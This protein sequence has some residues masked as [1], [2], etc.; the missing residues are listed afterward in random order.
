[1]MP[2]AAPVPA[3]AY[4]LNLPPATDNGL[5]LTLQEP[6]SVLD[7]ASNL[8]NSAAGLIS[9][10]SSKN[11]EEK[12]IGTVDVGR[13]LVDVN[14]AEHSGNPIAK[15]DRDTVIEESIGKPNT[16][17]LEPPHSLLVEDSEQNVR[18]STYTPENNIG[19]PPNK[20]E[21]DSPNPAVVG[22]IKH[23]AGI[24]NYSFDVPFASLPGRGIDAS[25]GMTYNSR[26]WN[27]TGEGSY[28]FY[29]Y[30]VDKNWIA[31]GF[32]FGYGKLTS[33]FQSKTVVLTNNQ[34][35]TFNEVVPEGFTDPD[36]TR[37]QIEC[38]ASSV[39][40]N[41]Q[42]FGGPST[43]C[44]EYGTMDGTFVKVIYNGTRI[45]SPYLVDDMSAYAT[46]YF[47]LI[48]AGGSKVTYTIPGTQFAA[49]DFSR[50]HYPTLIQD[51]NGNQ[52]NIAYK[53]GKDNIEY[54]R[55]TLGRQIK[56]YYDTAAEK[57]L[58]AVTVPGFN[59]GAERQT[60]RFYYEENVALNYQGKFT[61]YATAPATYRALKY[62]YFPST[63]AGYRYDYHPNF[64]MITKISKLTGMAVTG[65]S[66]TSTG[67]VTADG[68]TAST[69]E[70]TYP[71]DG[72]QTPLTDVPKYT[73]RTD[74]WQGRTTA[75]API[76]Y[77]D[78][79]EPAAGADRISAVI[80]KDTSFDIEYKTVSNN[81]L[82]WKNGLTKETIVT[83]L[84]GPSRQYRTTMAKT[85]YTWEEGIADASGR[86]IPIVR[87]VEVTNDAGQIKAVS[88][89]YDGYNNQTVVREHDLAAPGVLGNELRRTETT[90]ETGAGWITN[91]M[92]RLPKEIKTIVNNT[93]VSKVQ[94][95]YDNYVGNPLAP[96]PGVIQHDPAYNGDS[97][98]YQCNPHYVCDPGDYPPNCPLEYDQCPYSDP[99]TNFRGNVTKV[100]A[101]SNASLTTDPDASAHTM[102]YDSAGNVVEASM[103]CCN[104]KT[105]E[106]AAA[107]QYAYA[108]KETKGSSPQLVNEGTYDF[109]TGLPLSTKDENN[110]TTN[111][112]YDAATLRR[113]RVDA[114]NGAWSTVEYND[115]Q[116]PYSVKS[117]S[118]LDATRSISSWSFINGA[119]QG[120]RSRSL[121]ASGYISNDV[122]FDIMGRPT[123]SYNP[124]TVTGLSDARPAG[125]KYSEAIVIDPLGRTLSTKLPDDTIVQ[126]EYSG[127]TATMTDQAGKKR[128]QLA[129]ALG[130]IVRV[131]EPDAA[132][133]LGAVTTPIQP[134]FYEYDGN[135]NLI[136]VTQTGNGVTQE[137]L[138]KYDALSR[139][140]AE[141]QVEAAATLNDAG[142]KIGAGGLWTGVYKYNAD[143]LLLEGV[144]ARGVKSA[145][146]Y[147]GLNR[148]TS[149]TYTGE[150]G[151]QT[152]QVTYT[153][154]EAESGFF[155]VGRLTKVKTAAN[156]TY[157]TP[158]TIQNYDYDSVGQVVKHNQS[159]G[160]QS[161]NLEYGYNLAGQLI[162]E[163]YPSGKVVNMTVDN[164]GV[165]QTIADSQR[166]YLNGISINNQGLLSQLNLGNGNAETFSYNDRFQMTSQSLNKGSEV[167][168]KYDYS[169]GQTDLTTGN[170]DTTKNNEQLGKIESFIG[171]NKQASQRFAYDEL[172]RLSESRE[173]RGDNNSLTYKQK[174]DFDRF[175]NLYRK[176]ANNPT[177]GQANPL[178]Y[179][180]IEDA[181]ISKATNRFATGTTYDEAGQ[182]VTDN[183]FRGGMNFAY[184]AN[185]RNVKV[186]KSN[187]TDA[188]TVYDALGNRV[189]TKIND[190]WQYIIYDA[191]GQIVAEYGAPSGSTGGVKYIQQDW[192]GSVRAVTSN[193]GFVISRTDH[194]AFGEEVGAGVGMRTSGQGYSGGN[195][196]RQGYGLT[197]KDNAS[198]Q[199]HTW[200]RKLETQAGKWSSPDPYKGS[201]SLGDPQSFN[202]YSYV[203][204]QPT[205]FVD[206]SGL[207]IN[208]VCSAEFGYAACNFFAGGFFGR[209]LADRSVSGVL[210][211]SEFRQWWGDGWNY[212]YFT[213]YSDNSFSGFG[214]RRGG[215]GSSI[216][217]ETSKCISKVWAKFNLPKLSQEKRDAFNL[218][219]KQLLDKFNFGEGQASE[220][221]RFNAGLVFG[222]AITG[223]VI[224]SVA[225]GSF[226]G[227]VGAAI[228]AFV[229]V[230][231]GVASSL[232]SEHQRREAFVFDSKQIA[233]RNPEAAKWYA[234]FESAA[235]EIRTTCIK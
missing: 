65:N 43:Y 20:A 164:F 16:Q 166:T 174:F 94:Y 133:N 195:A 205:N 112:T 143:S 187:V 160:N 175:G 130:R 170:I 198:G 69:T 46:T 108:T 83:Q 203:E 99:S 49:N 186:S 62:V 61:G 8:F 91:R 235:N 13:L 226:A 74:D 40:P 127:L 156:T 220:T 189:A 121:T 165:M 193:T 38:K 188:W 141:K 107:N 214:G 86:K 60:I 84:Y 208:E 191:L 90:Y 177:T 142:V 224:E 225:I 199:Q 98:T 192:Q 25:I 100:T 149:V 102:K 190:V 135:D 71:N 34:Y 212:A 41:T 117:T 106:Y 211:V 2:I 113:T 150:T 67:S 114:P 201:M 45:L 147:D 123:R 194:Q 96:T 151:Y 183:K 217:D 26:V 228:G 18:D 124:Y 22:R 111:F 55:D 136:K 1:M 216:V 213:S 223:W 196:A 138:F 176:A 145:F 42:S 31:P 179:T 101:F 167:L 75:A 19:S 28:G 144:D 219:K 44:T 21:L 76:T 163:K 159:I 4:D 119:G 52:I 148:V 14:G 66:L 139:L 17:E 232:F 157:G 70:Y 48:H 24:A 51:R 30:N 185:G 200:F 81:T 131:D 129:D 47:T 132:G 92:F 154:S 140:I 85:V 161:Y 118:S 181:D 5:R 3:W 234:L 153:Y 231:A 222:S 33:H 79:P 73:Q 116:F 89:E 72:S 11:N 36:G 82:D 29:Q 229:G 215:G 122:E 56:F 125:I 126:S 169:Y 180:P 27:K 209:S 162:S 137:R 227:P 64:G 35:K 58:V 104:I 7:A 12:R 182:V 105:I 233:E 53:D 6:M 134:T 207:A 10:F 50:D 158:E 168:Q 80:V 202:R 146:A 78:S 97:T 68:A 32:T 206:P 59:G 152:P 204:N 178:P 95:E 184:D 93:A 87:K 128:R 37:H 120:F 172:G 77:Y 221:D 63:G 88:F 9:L 171:A 210:T 197:E 173:Y 109:N 155:N 103:S 115:T 54:I 57:K 23:L 110:Q 39:I 218:E 230:G 15:I